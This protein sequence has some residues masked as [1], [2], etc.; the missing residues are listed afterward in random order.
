MIPAADLLRLSR[1]RRDDAVALL[2][3]GRYDGA[4]YMCGYAIELALKARICK[5]LKWTAF[6]DDSNFRSLKTHSLEVLLRFSG[7]EQKIKRRA[8]IPWSIVK[9]WTPELRYDYTSTAT[10][11]SAQHMIT[12]VETILRHL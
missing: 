11:Q 2:Q 7:V 12:A 1:V 8:L 4:I 3:A 5:T 9:T 6:P 10:A